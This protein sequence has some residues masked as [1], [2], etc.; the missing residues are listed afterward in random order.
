SGNRCWVLDESLSCQL[1]KSMAVI[2]QPQI[3]SGPS[4]CQ[5][6]AEKPILQLSSELFTPIN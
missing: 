5:H 3:M 1:F 2:R 6:R 4:L